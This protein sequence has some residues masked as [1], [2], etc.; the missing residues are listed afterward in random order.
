MLLVGWR[1]DFTEPQAVKDDVNFVGLR[2]RLSAPREE[3]SAL[4]Y[5][6]SRSTDITAGKCGTNP[7]YGLIKR[8]E[9]PEQSILRLPCHCFVLS[10]ILLLEST[11][12]FGC[13][14]SCK[15]VPRRM[16]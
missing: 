3:K 4:E 9:N 14:C 12:S 16:R 13:A 10:P 11:G 5:V 15:A 7:L 8:M 1:L 6:N 2:A